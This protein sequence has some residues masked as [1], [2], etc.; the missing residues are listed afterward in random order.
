MGKN[1]RGVLFI[2]QYVADN[3]GSKSKRV[4]DMTFRLGLEIGL[5]KVEDKTAVN[6]KI[7][8]MARSYKK[9]EKEAQPP[10]EDSD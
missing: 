7:E 9:S 6:Y 8:Q 10:Q 3:E 2:H 5:W 4:R 1:P